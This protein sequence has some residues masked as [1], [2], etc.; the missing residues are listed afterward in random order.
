[1]RHLLF[2]ALVLVLAG[3]GDGRFVTGCMPDGSPVFYQYK[4]TS[5]NYEGAKTSP[6]NC[7]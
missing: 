3:C 2:G 6:E 4:N 5:G 7:Q 1:M